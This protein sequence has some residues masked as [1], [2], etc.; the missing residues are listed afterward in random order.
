MA[1]NEKWQREIPVRIL[2]HFECVASNIESW[3]FGVTANVDRPNNA[4]TMNWAWARLILRCLA[5][6]AK[7]NGC[8][9]DPDKR[10]NNNTRPMDC[11]W[12]RCRHLHRH[13]LQRWGVSH[14][15]IYNVSVC[16]SVV[17]SSTFTS[18]EIDIEN[19]L[20]FSVQNQ[21]LHSVLLVDSMHRTRRWV[22]QIAD[23]L[24]V[25][26]GLQVL[27]MALFAPSVLVVV[28]KGWIDFVR[29]AGSKCNRFEWITF[30]WQRR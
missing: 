27:R 14:R 1:Q 23:A 25:W 29:T 21:Y 13:R 28:W 11:W 20:L 26:T 3:P 10:I 24:F 6:D 2:I 16:L 12:Y 5:L 4:R 18:F 8:D 22:V 17:Q 19:G 9:P 30:E 7:T 15:H